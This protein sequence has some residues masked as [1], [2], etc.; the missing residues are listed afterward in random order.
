MAKYS[1]GHYDGPN[2]MHGVPTW[3]VAGF[4][5]NNSATN[6]YLFM[7]WYVAYYLTGF[8][9]A[10]VI[11]AGSFSMISRIWDGVTD[12][13]VGLIVDRTNGKFGKNRPF[14]VIGNVTM[15]VS[16]F[17][18]YYVTPLLPQGIRLVWFFIINAIFYL[19]YT[20]Q[21]IITKAGQ[22]CLTND[23]K[24]R[25][26]F[27]VVDGICTPVVFALGEMLVS[28]V[29]VPK[30]GKMEALG[31]FQE[32]FLVMGISSAILTAIAFISIA[33]KDNIKYFGTGKEQKVGFKDY[34]DVLMHNRAIQMLVASASTDKLGMNAK[35]TTVTLIL[36]G[37]VAGNYA[38]SGIVA[39]YTTIVTIAFILFG[40]GYI[41]REMG[42]KRALVVGSIGCVITNAL[43]MALWWFGDPS[44]LSLPGDGAFTGFTFFTIAFVALY[45][46]AQGMQNISSAVVITMTADCT[47]YETYRTGR[48]VPG[49]IG[50]LFSFV[51]KMVSSV[52]PM[53]A[54]LMLA[55]IGFKDTMPDIGTPLTPQLKFVG[56]FLAFGILIIMNGVN[57]IAMHFYPL[58]KK[59]MEEIQDE[60]AAIKAKA[61]TA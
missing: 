42:Q 40:V 57:L 16:V 49:M 25:P 3:R 11:L 31:V 8:V 1:D 47:D 39:G 14:M 32:M 28:L 12:P 18:M 34:A 21:C 22:S 60:I 2:G 46:I 5:L 54:S 20:C 15:F 23:P 59:K 48:Y 33:P 43:M 56:L 44:T 6:C 17:L 58:D 52:A 26:I 13:F 53:I 45:L 51:D 55:A 50:T 24:Q 41:A 9:G 37:I 30:Y 27:G 38:L 61:A 29:L 35:T 19:G 10:G 36:F 7:T 4:S